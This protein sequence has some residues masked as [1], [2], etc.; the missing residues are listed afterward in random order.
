M[1]TDLI[2]AHNHQIPEDITDQQY[3]NIME[4]SIVDDEKGESLEY[5]HLIKFD[6]HKKIWVKYFANELG[7]L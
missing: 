1:G 4:R 2:T 6:R 7:C 5:R 3:L